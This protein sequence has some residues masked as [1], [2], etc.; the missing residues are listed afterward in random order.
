MT[1]CELG[2]GEVRVLTLLQTFGPS[3]VTTLTAKLDCSMAVVSLALRSAMKRKLVDVCEDDEDA[4]VRTYWITNAGKVAL[5][6]AEQEFCNGMKRA[7][8]MLG[9]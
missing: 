3:N 7:V 5:R 4:R 8:K 1:S 9:K 2:T 6:E